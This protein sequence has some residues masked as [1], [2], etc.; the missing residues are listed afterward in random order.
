MS[1]CP[2]PDPGGAGR[3]RTPQSASGEYLGGCS[4]CD[5][6]KGEEGTARRWLLPPKGPPSVL[7]HPLFPAFLSQEG[8][9]AAGSQVGQGWERRLSPG[10]LSAVLHVPVG[11]KQHK[12][13]GE[14]WSGIPTRLCCWVLLPSQPVPLRATSPHLC[15]LP[16]PPKL[17]WTQFSVT[18]LTFLLLRT[19]AWPLGV[20]PSST[21]SAAR[22]VRG[23][24]GGRV[25]GRAQGW[26]RLSSGT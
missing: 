2:H 5:R 6:L 26:K 22:R 21:E 25:P 15:P 8:S 9:R 7:T 3:V 10:Q 20:L 18:S 23:S 14:G 24:P 11:E 17:G 13:M 4:G 1:L 16:S 19:H 12:R